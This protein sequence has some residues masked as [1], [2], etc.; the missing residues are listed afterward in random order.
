MCRNRALMLLV[1]AGAVFAI[2]LTAFLSILGV[3]SS[4]AQQAAMHNCPLAGKWAI[5]VWEGSDGTDTGQALATC[6]ADAVAAAYYVDPSTQ[7]WLRYFVGRAEVSNLLALDTMQGV[8]ALGGAGAPNTPTPS[9]TQTP[10]TTPTRTPTPTP[11]ATATPT[12]EPTFTPQVEHRLTLAAEPPEGGTTSPSPGTH[13]YAHGTTVQVHAEASTDWWFD[14]WSGDCS[15]D[16]N[17]TDITV[18]M[19]ANKICTANFRGCIPVIQGTYHGAVQLN[20]VPAPDGTLVE[21]FVGG[22]K[23]AEDSTSGGGQYVFD[24]PQGSLPIGPP[25]F[26]GG[27]ITFQANGVTC[28][29]EPWWASGLHLLDLTCGSE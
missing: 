19:N 14:Y 29:E 8:V 10:T 21:A 2:G 25:C 5:S 4:A 24:I 15:G 6:G 1:V 17:D 9:A 20:G 22:L 27:Q 18:H 16:D 7:A 28:E 12:P 13:W 3:G 11:T 26:E 23:W